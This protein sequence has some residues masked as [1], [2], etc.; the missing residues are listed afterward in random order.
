MGYIKYGIFSRVGPFVNDFHSIRN[1]ISYTL[2]YAQID[3]MN[4]QKESSIAHFAIFAENGIFFFT[5]T[6]Q[7]LTSRKR[8]V[9]ALWRYIHQNIPPYANWRKCDLH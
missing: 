1:L 5:T 2:F 4:P 9:L 7:S 3:H 8:Q 6:V